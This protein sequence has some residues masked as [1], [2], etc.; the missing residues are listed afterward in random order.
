MRQSILA[1][2]AAVG[3]LTAIAPAF[4][5]D[6]FLPRK[7]TSS[8]M[9]A[10]EVEGSTL[11]P[12]GRTKGI[13]HNPKTGHSGTID[14]LHET[15]KDGRLCHLYRYTF[16]TGTNSDNTPYKLNWCKMSNGEWKIAN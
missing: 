1:V 3:L 14:L 12:G 13:W 7:L 5:Q 10:L 16:K 11:A 4:A 9:N 2:A 6:Y 15:K 8:D